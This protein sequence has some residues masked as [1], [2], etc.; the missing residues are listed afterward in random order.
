M[1][2]SKKKSYYAKETIFSS[3][4][5]LSFG[6]LVILDKCYQMYMHILLIILE[7]YKS[8]L[9]RVIMHPLFY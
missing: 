8:I 6:N 1:F 2:L 3:L 5:N 4:Y 7:Q 9:F